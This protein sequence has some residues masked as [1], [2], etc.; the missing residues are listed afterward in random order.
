[1]DRDEG[2]V[3]CMGDAS[4]RVERRGM[5]NLLGGIVLPVCRGI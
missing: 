3:A 5:G 4:R 1:M 2:R